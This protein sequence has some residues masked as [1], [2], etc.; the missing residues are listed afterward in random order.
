M[1]QVSTASSAAATEDSVPLDPWS[2]EGSTVFFNGRLCAMRDAKVS[3]AAPALNYGTGCFEGIRAYWSADAGQLYVLKLREHF[4]RFAGSCRMLKIGLP[5]SVEELCDVTLEL[6]RRNGYREDV[7]IRPLAFKGGASIKL[8]LSGV[9]DELAIFTFPFG[10]Y[11]D[12]SAGL[13]VQVSSWRR[14]SDNAIPARSKV[15]GAYI[16]S[17]LAVDDAHEAGFDEAIFLTADGHVSEGSSCNVFLVRG[18]RLITPPVTADILEGIT[19]LAVMEVA[20]DTLGLDVEE[21]DVDRSEL[22]VADEVFF[23]GTGVQVSPVTRVDG[24]AVGAGRPGEITTRLQA[25]YFDA[26]RGRDPRYSSWLTP[27]Y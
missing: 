14:I 15:T 1:S 17:A 19:R 12:I 16:N 13:S 5:R 23:C 9:P 26:V 3:V 18:G 25:A 2:L 6:L 8:G 22:Y 27:V 4:E 20:R 10:N 11:V 7:Y 24:R 21:R